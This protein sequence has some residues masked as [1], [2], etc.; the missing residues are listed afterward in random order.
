MKDIIGKY[1]GDKIIIE[2]LINIHP[3]KFEYKR[4]LSHYTN[5]IKELKNLDAKIE[6]EKIEIYNQ[7]VED[8]IDNVLIKGETVNTNKELGSTDSIFVHNDNTDDYYYTI[9]H[10]S[11]R[12]LIKP[13][14]D[15][16]EI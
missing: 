15:E 5:F 8:C 10:Q 9:D 6:R 2:E 7:A 4:M 16:T 14:P 12:K 3:H 1:E 11:M 13:Y